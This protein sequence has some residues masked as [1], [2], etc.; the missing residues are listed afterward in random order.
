MH[1]KKVILITLFFFSITS[2]FSQELRDSNDD[3]VATIDLLGNV[4]DL[5][6]FKIISFAASGDI[7]DVNNHKIG[8]IDGDDFKDMNG[9][10][11]GSLNII[12]GEVFNSN[13]DKLGQINNKIIQDNKLNQIGRITGVVNT[14]HIAAF[15]FFF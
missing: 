3:V 11:L 13:G 8:Y 10:I 9:D 14:H 7:F 1:I 4:Y 5:Q 6:N 15:Y 2:A 12:S